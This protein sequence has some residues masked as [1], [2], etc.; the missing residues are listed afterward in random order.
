[1]ARDDAGTARGRGLYDE[2]S[3]GGDKSTA[4][5]GEDYGAY[6]DTAAPATTEAGWGRLLMPGRALLTGNKCVLWPPHVVGGVG[7]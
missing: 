1:M 4:G 6:E 2:H 5:D 3:Q 7:A